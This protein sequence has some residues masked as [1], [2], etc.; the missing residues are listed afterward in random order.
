[1]K[2]PVLI[3]IKPDGMVK[4][5]MG[6]LLTRL[7]EMKLQLVAAKLVAVS[8]D[9]AEEHY[10]HHR[11]KFFFEE[12]VQYLSGQLHKD[13]KVLAL[14]YY[15]ELAIK[16][17][18]DMAGATNPEEANPASVRGAV[19]RITTKGVYENVLHVSSDSKEAEREI[20]LWFKPEEIHIRLYHS[21]TIDGKNSKKQVWV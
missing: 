17:A 13:N 5:L 14:I 11:K 12:I 2:E 7:A 8:R 15:G 18:R 1:M 3:L 20:K 9:L 6:Y 10:H 21:K 19:G 4:F 16:K